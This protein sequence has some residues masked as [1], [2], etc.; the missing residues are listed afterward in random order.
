MAGTWN[1]WQWGADPE[2]V[3]RSVADAH[4]RFTGS[5][6]LSRGVRSVVQ[7]S[8]RR[9][10]LHGVDPDSTLPRIEL[11][12]SD[13]RDHRETHPL[14]AVMPLLRRLL[15]E[16]APGPQIVAIGDTSGRLMWVEGDHRLR[17][18]AEDMCFVEGAN[19]NEGSAGTN[20]PGTALAL[21]HAVQVFASEHF[22]RGVHRWSCSAALL[23]DPD[24]G[25]VLGVL[26]LT[27]EDHIASPQ[28]LAL[29]R[30]AAAAAET[31]LRALRLSGRLPMPR[32]ASDPTS[33]GIPRAGKLPKAPEA[34]N[35]RP[36]PASRPVI[37]GGDGRNTGDGGDGG[38][39]RAVAQPESAGEGGGV[40]EVVMEVLGRDYAR[41][42]LDGHEF[43][44]SVRHSEILLLLARNP[45]GLTGEELGVHLNERDTAPVTVR[46][47]MSRLRRLLGPGAL[48]SRPYRLRHT[49]HTDIDRVRR[50]LTNGSYRR[51]LE[52]YA[53]PV[54]PRSEAPGVAEVREGLQAEVGAAFG[55]SGDPDVLLTWVEHPEWRDDPRALS[56]ALDA[57]DPASP[58]HAALR[59]RL[60]WLAG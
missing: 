60:R 3:R 32:L 19:W 46:A 54:L 27:G 52:T 58:W 51:A 7:D 14:A 31:E 15:V 20:A 26:D 28:A 24:T 49:V 41:L 43:D 34:G 57:L 4:E 17:S 56:V 59:G 21:D 13:L 12:G 9:S 2:V 50:H 42:V 16:T 10:A 45:A 37:V 22:A 1:A 44:L 33:A 5:G 53:G 40:Q 39:A 6:Q 48:D 11:A 30:T 8:W 47:E 35:K 25:T 38:P 36:R 18:R 29:V 55:E 23:R